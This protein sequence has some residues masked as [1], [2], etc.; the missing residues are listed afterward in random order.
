MSAPWFVVKYIPDLYRREPRNVGV[1]L[2]TEEQ[3]GLVR[4]IGQDP[5]SGEVNPNWAA[6]VV[7]ETRTY[8]QWVNYFSYHATGGSWGKALESLSRRQFDNF[9]VEEGGAYERDF[10]D[11]NSVLEE[12]FRSLVSDTP[13][14]AQDSAPAKQLRTLVKQV[15]K[16]AHIENRVETQ[17]SYELEVQGRRSRA[18]TT[19][20]FDYR[21]VDEATTLME[22]VPLS[23]RRPQENSETVDALLYRI[24]QVLKTGEAENFIAFYHLPEQAT[25]EQQQILQPHIRHLE[26]YADALEVG[27]VT[28]A[29]TN[30]R[31]RLSLA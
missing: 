4:F 28:F 5:D 11:P 17:P 21:Y 10:D 7:P 16:A 13:L 6:D 18:L 12:L 2:L 8:R 25:E 24:E 3:R 22:R 1:V 30:L 31:Q 15:F 29:A 19:V 23:L 26:T 27:D 9:Y 14:P 20:R